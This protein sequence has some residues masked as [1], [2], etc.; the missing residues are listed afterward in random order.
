MSYEYAKSSDTTRQP[1]PGEQH[2]VHYYYTERAKMEEMI[3][4]G[5][6]LENA[7]FGDNLYGT[8]Y[9]IFDTIARL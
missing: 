7:K 4:N 2:G 3:K 5:E 9:G 8:R 1:R 6:F